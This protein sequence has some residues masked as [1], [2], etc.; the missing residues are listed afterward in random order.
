M[1]KISKKDSEAQRFYWLEDSTTDFPYYNGQPVAISAAQWLFVMLMVLAGIM[2]VVLPVPMFAGTAGQFV[3]ALLI[4]I[5]P[6]AALAKV[7]PAHWMAIFK[8]VAWRDV[9]LMA[10]FALLNILLTFFMGWVVFKLTAVT[11]NPVNSMLLQMN[12]LDKTLF[13][14]KTIPQLL[15]EELI[16]I[17]PFLAILFF[18]SQYA[19]L[20]R[21]SAILLAWLLSSLLF[22]LVHLPTYGW[23]WLQCVVVIGCARLVLTLPWMMTKNVWVSTGAHII[24][25]WL[26]FSITL[27]GA[28]LATKV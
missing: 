12:S 11:S 16:T 6:L 23:N 20:N 10:G 8:P 25:D 22:A 19:G 28:G 7:I 21:K 2:A 15:G 3:P 9:R 4:V 26:L 5:L 1:T 24:N 14:I 17:L 27:L 18:G 13:F